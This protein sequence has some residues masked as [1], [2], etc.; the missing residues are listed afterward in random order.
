M[1]CPLR[2]ISKPRFVLSLAS[3]FLMLTASRVAAEEGGS[4]LPNG[5]FEQGEKHP[6][7]WKVEGDVSLDESDKVEG[8]R[9]LLFRCDAAT[10]PVTDAISDAVKITPGVWELSGATAGDLYSPDVSFNVSVKICLFDA[11][12]REVGTKSIAII[13]N[14]T[15]WKRFKERF[16]A[17]ANVATARVAIEFNKT[18]GVF[19]ADDFSLKFAGKS[20]PMEGGERRAIFTTSRVGC[21]FYPGDDLSMYATLE[22]PAELAGG[23]LRF[24][25]QLTD[26]WGEQLAPKQTATLVPSGKT[27]NGWNRYRATLDLNAIPLKAGPYYEV[28]TVIDLGAPFPAKDKASFAILPEAATRNYDPMQVPFGAHTWNATVYDYFP[29]SAR[30]GI[31]RCLVFWNWPKE[32]PYTPDFDKGYNYDSRLGWPKRFGMLPYGVL[33]PVT[34]IEHNEPGSHHS[35]EALREGIRQSI[36]KYKK[37]GLW[38]FQIGNEPPHWN[39]EM[40]RKDVETYKV[41]YEAIKKTDPSII[42]IGSAIGPN[43]DFFKAGFQPYQDV[44]NIHVYN[45]LGEL[46]KSMKKYRE[47]FEKYGGRKPIWATEIGSNS[48]GLPRHVI[49]KDIIRKVV[50]FMADGGE[51]FTW[52]ATGGMPDPKG[53]R[54]SNGYSDSMDLFDSKFNMFLPRLDAVAY[55]HV[56]NAICVKKFIKEIDYPCGVE[57]YLFRDKDANCLL[58]FWNTKASGD[59]FVALPGVNDVDVKHYDGLETRLNA[60][61]EGINLRI[62]DDPVMLTFRGGE[63]AIPVELPASRVSLPHLP[64]AIVQGTSFTFDVMLSG[65][66]KGAPVLAGPPLW[67]ISGA[68]PP[69]TDGNTCVKYTVF[70]P[71][72][73]TAQLATFKLTSEAGAGFGGTELLFGIPVKSRIEVSIEPLADHESGKAGVNLILANNS[74]RQET[75]KWSAELVD[76]TP[77]E[78]GT[79]NF[80]DS[81]P[82]SALFARDASDKTVLDPRETKAIPLKIDKIDRL[83]IYKIRAT[84]TD[85][86]GNPVT[87]ERFVG[88][89]ARVP[90]RTGDI[91]LDG[92]LDEEAWKNAPACDLNEARQFFISIPGA[93]PWGGPQDLSGT[94]RF[95]WDDEHLYVGVN[96]TDDVFCNTKQDEEIWNGDSLQF[97]I[98]PFR[99]EA[100]GKGR[101][102][103]AFG[104][105]KKG[106]QASCHLSADPG[107]PAGVV[108]EIRVFTKRLDPSNGAMSYEIAIPWS[109]LAPF[110][111]KASADLGLSM[112]INEDDGTGRKSFIGW[113]GGVHLKETDFVGDLILEK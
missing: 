81:R 86:N 75:V 71:D 24:A 43:E 56:I 67:K 28:R 96:V 23:K 98:N 105:G 38:A 12:D 65:K 93:K 39:P 84:A 40:I 83:T 102:D 55:Y 4:L 111:P 62:G 69:A 30:L 61:A 63:G 22:T 51:F 37:E 72:E 68:M 109:R 52:F 48:Q 20:I 25:W 79:F 14:K 78:N 31:R 104:F 9:S 1:P 99:Q 10:L 5:N 54:S 21:L 91:H 90:R 82:A 2:F 34:G 7:N 97:L 70:V 74:D 108:P 47:L 88:G 15:G 113:F 11:A 87:R 73:T 92:S 16:E 45:D 18:H 27:G 44:Y 110:K 33:Y 101:Y 46:R 8:K 59:F 89:F 3:V 17:G 107:A 6:A 19:R 57:G 13:T 66:I 94:M 64:G 100:Q 85:S 53:E 76:E 58:V 80:K 36:G 49:A 60:G 77:M 112:I 26:Y 41:V 42:A 95:L 50:C 103:Y 32:A 106:N 29:L 35:E